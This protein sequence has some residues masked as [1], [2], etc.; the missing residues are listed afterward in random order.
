MLFAQN[1]C[2]A[3][4]SYTL[5]QS[6]KTAVFTN[7]SVGTGLI[8]IW[9]FGDNT[10][11]SAAS[12]T[13]TFSAFGTYTVCLTITKSDSSCYHT[14]C[15][16]LVIAAPCLSSWTVA[17]ATGHNLS[18]NFAS[19]NTSLDYNYFWS[20]GD[21]INSDSK[22]PNHVYSHAGRYKVCLRVTKKD[23]S[24][25]TQTCDSITVSANTTTPCVATWTVTSNPNTLPFAR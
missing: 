1:N 5:N 13:K 3:N 22:T 21:G 12:P 6:S 15:S 25:T 10:T 17:T 4:F 8:Y 11:S 20:F 16:T 23:S 2:E 18:K 24:C 7:I 9:T 19:N 14:R